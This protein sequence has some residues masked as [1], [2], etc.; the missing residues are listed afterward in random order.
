MPN[1]KKKKLSKRQKEVLI[2]KAI[3]EFGDRAVYDIRN[4]T[5]GMTLYAHADTREIS[6]N[7]RKLIPSDWNGLKTIV[8]YFE[9]PEDEEYENEDLYDPF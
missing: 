4:G 3:T 5:L 8:T 6:R 2:L 9:E 7:L 1:S